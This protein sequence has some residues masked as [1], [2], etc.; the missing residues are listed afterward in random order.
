MGRK[1]HFEAEKQRD[2]MMDHSNNFLV[3]KKGCQT[4][5]AFGYFSLCQK[6]DTNNLYTLI[7]Q[8][9]VFGYNFGPTQI[10]NY[11]SPN[12]VLIK[13]ATSYL[14]STGL[15]LAKTVVPD[16]ITSNLSNF[17]RDFAF[18]GMAEE[19][20]LLSEITLEELYLQNLNVFTPKSVQHEASIVTANKK[21]LGL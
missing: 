20:Y 5:Q 1:Q 6:N 8:F 12:S 16:W 17:L 7:S 19:A 21:L 2:V 10:Y 14:L 4:E 11:D 15:T 18:S 9:N 3:K 13:R